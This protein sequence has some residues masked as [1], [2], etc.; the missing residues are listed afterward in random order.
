M[1]EIL[2]E[3]VVEPKK[4]VRVVRE[5]M[6]IRVVEKGIIHSLRMKDLDFFVCAGGC[7]RIGH[8]IEDVLRVLVLVPGLVFSLYNVLALPSL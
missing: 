1:G 3:R 4:H 2:G 7:G 8:P 6:S 5:D